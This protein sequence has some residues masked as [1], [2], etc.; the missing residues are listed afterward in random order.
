MGAAKAKYLW[1]A[2]RGLGLL[3]TYDALT[4]DIGD[5]IHLGEA[6][7]DPNKLTPDLL[8]T[9]PAGN[10]VFASLR[11]P[12]P[13]TGDPH[14]ATGSQPGL[15]VFQVTENGASGKLKAV[16]PITNPN[17][18][19]VDLADAHGVQVRRK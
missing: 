12:T 10:L 19:G 14:V 18:A 5:E 17:A 7:D 16:V 1:V 9:N 6:H 13:L 15:G 4:F 2:D 11:G 3:T 8:D